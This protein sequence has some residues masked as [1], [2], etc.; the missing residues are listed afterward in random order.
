MKKL[1]ILLGGL[2]LGISAS[3]KEIKQVPVEI[4][5]EESVK[6]IEKEVIVYR[7]RV[8]KERFRP[9]GSLNLEYR[10]YGDTEGQNRNGWNGVNNNYSRT[11][12]EGYIQTT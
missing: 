3:A 5:V 9:N 6:V 1:G 7:D 8:V 10:Y 11:Q 12:L 2:A 4:L